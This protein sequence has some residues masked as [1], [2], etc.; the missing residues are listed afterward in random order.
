MYRRHLPHWRQDGATYFVTFRLADSI[1]QEH[2]Q[3]LKRWRE[4]WERENPEPRSETQWKTLAREITGKTERWLDDGYGECVL[5]DLEIAKLMEKSLLNFQNERYFVS[6]LVVMPNHVHCV[7]KPLDE[8]DL[9]TILK[10]MKG[11]VARQINQRLNRSEQLWEQESY[12]RIVRDEEHLWQ[13]VQYI[14]NNGAKA[15]LRPDQYRRWIHPEWIQ[16]GLR[17]P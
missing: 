2:L 17:F 13:I 10:N 16:A 15:R 3:S 5:A 8:F 7:M 6:C 4:I 9:E 12:D 14:G 1:P 11:Y